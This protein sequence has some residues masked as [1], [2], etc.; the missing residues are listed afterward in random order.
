MTALH[1]ACI[2][3]N[4][5]PAGQ[6]LIGKTMTCRADKRAATASMNS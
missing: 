3:G 6:W 2:S 4:D 1:T 5:L